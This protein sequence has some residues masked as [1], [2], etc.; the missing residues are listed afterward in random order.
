MIYVRSLMYIH[1]LI[2]NLMF[3]TTYMIIILRMQGNLWS[4]FCLKNQQSHYLC[5]AKLYELYLQ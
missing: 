2:F 4:Y 3:E 5:K 1:M